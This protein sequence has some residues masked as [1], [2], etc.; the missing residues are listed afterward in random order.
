[1]SKEELER[2][3]ISILAN[4]CKKASESL[5]GAAAKT[6]FNLHHEWTLLVIRE[7]PHAI[8]DQTAKQI[9]AAKDVLKQRM[10]EYL[11]VAA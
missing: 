1:M 3:D 9:R 5:D 2:Q 6:G 10:V 8:D 11:L 7:T 4:R